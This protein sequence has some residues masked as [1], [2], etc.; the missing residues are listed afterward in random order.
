MD[1]FFR[2]NDL[3]INSD[4]VQYIVFILYYMLVSFIKYKLLLYRKKVCH[5]SL[6]STFN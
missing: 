2:H 1:L 5:I 6:H 4:G 3:Y